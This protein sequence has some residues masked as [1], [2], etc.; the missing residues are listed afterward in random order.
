LPLYNEEKTKNTSLLAQLSESQ[1]QFQQYFSLYNEEKANNGNLILQV[2]AAQAESQKYL[3][4]YDQ[5]QADLQLERRSKAG[6]KG[7]ETRRKRENERLK[8]EISEMMV[9]LRDAMERKEIAIQNLDVLADRMDKI[10]SLV[11]SVEADPN[12]SNPL[13]LLAKFK[14]MWRAIQEILAE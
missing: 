2:Q 6:I 12:D 1:Q 14:R 3:T 9:V 4:L 13:G 8:Q 11:D 7:W 10:Q 5:S